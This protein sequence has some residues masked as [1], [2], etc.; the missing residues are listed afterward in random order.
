MT[1]PRN[2]RLRLNWLRDG[3]NGTDVG[4]RVSRPSQAMSSRQPGIAMLIAA[5]E[6]CLLLRATVIPLRRYLA[7]MLGDP[8]MQRIWRTM[9]T[10]ASTIDGCESVDQPKAYLFT[11]A[12]RLR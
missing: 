12:R 5:S 7:R 3:S 1:G 10:S 2:N 8:A 9:P 11:T 6:F 4:F